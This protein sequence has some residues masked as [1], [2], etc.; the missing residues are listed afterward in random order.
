MSES[1]NPFKI[2]PDHS[3]LNVQGVLYPISG[4]IVTS[5]TP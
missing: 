5:Y 4:G 1:V 2:N 3:S